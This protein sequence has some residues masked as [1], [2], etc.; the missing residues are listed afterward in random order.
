MTFPLALAAIGTHV[1]AAGTAVSPTIRDVAQGAPSAVNA[2][3]LRYWYQGDVPAPHFPGGQTMTTIMVGERVNVAAYWPA[4][5]RAVLAGLDSWVRAVKHE[6][7][8]RLIGD[9]QLGGQCDDLEVGDAEVEYLEVTGALV[10]RLLI[11]LT[12]D[13]GEAYTISA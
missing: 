12:L 13:F 3:M 9:S 6:L 5:D 7:K 2:P 11:P 8:T 1:T 4:S 10:V